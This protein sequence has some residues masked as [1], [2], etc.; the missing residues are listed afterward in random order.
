[1][2]SLRL[3]T[4]SPCLAA[5]FFLVPVPAFAQDPQP[6]L[7]PE[8]ERLEHW[9]DLRYGM[10]IHWG[11]NCQKGGEIG[12]SRQGPRRGRT[13]GG[14]GHI[15]VE[16]Y[17]N[18]YKT[19]DPV[20]FDADEWVTI[21]KDAGMKYMVLTS[22]HHDGFSMFASELTEYD[23]MATPFGRDVV[24][25]LAE[26]CARGGLEFGVYYSPRD[27]YHPDFAT[28]RHDRY[29]EF[30]LGQLRELATSYENLLVLWFDGLDSPRKLWKN[31]PEESFQLLRTLQPNILLNNR[32]G[33]PGDFDTPEQRIGA[34]QTDRPWETCMTICRQWS[35]KPDD[36]M[37][38]LEECVHTLV[39]TVGGDGNLLFNVG[40]MPDGRIEPRQVERLR[41]EGAWLAPRSEAFYAT[42]GGPFRPGKWGASTHAKDRIFLHILDWREEVGLVLPPIGPAVKGASLLPGGEEVS[43]AQTDE[44]VLVIVPAELRDELDTIVV[45]SLDGDASAIPPAAVVHHSSSL[46]YGK[47][48]RASNVY[49]KMKEYAPE[50][51]FDDDESTRWAT[52]AG[53]SACWIEV[54]LEEPKTVGSVALDQ[55]EARIEKY[56]LQLQRNGE[57]VT[58]H[59]GAKL[60]KKATIEFEPV[61]VRTFRLNIL[62]ASEGP[63]IYE[64]HLLAP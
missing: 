55:Y 58:F 63:T 30:Y 19:F 47:S 25:E 32:G 10:F 50:K 34:F 64:I 24:K 61:E 40:P 6:W 15:P 41:E 44:G 1:M 2:K 42:R 11:P 62:E 33:L 27:W 21:A 20:K 49:R 53:T 29:L 22:K 3:A 56:E 54:D 17:D 9:K 60:E 18:L 35:W 52:D 4:L 45:L 26:A 16:V 12:W 28:E 8:P 38:S 14:T 39:R 43:Y 51:A 13:R 59:R 46:A 36:R 37:K 48:A 5:A 57:W 23:V 31:T 7:T